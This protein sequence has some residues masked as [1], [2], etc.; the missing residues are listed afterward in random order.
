M[1]ADT[2]DQF[3]SPHPCYSLPHDP[4]NT[5]A[6]CC[7]SCRPLTTAFFTKR[8]T[9]VRP[10]MCAFTAAAGVKFMGLSSGLLVPPSAT[11][12]NISLLHLSR[13]LYV[14]RGFVF[15]RLAL[16]HAAFRQML[17]IVGAPSSLCCLCRAGGCSAHKASFHVIHQTEPPEFGRRDFFAAIPTPSY[18]THGILQSQGMLMFC[19]HAGR[20]EAAGLHRCILMHILL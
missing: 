13:A 15:G 18:R 7:C 8:C 14:E 17:C 10:A 12:L 4:P 2:G 6:R 16:D 1:R 11:S 9:G 20:G 5:A 3:L 19:L